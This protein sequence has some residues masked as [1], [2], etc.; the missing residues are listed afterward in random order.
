[1]ALDD[2]IT[3]IIE[4]LPED[5]GQV[6]LNV[7]MSQL[8]RLSATISRLDRDANEGRPGSYFRIAE[9]SYSS[10]MRVVIEPHSLP[11]QRYIGHMVV[12]SLN[13]I[14]EV[15]KHGDDLLVLEADLLE[16][17]RGLAKPVGK[18]LKNATLVFDGN[19]IDLT[20]GMTRRLDEAL[21]VDE[22]CD[23]SIDGMLEQ[24][25]IHHGA[26]TFHIFP[27]IGP[28][29]VSCRFPTKL[30]DEAV[31]AVGRRVEVSGTLHY[32]ANASFPHQIA[33]S[34]IEAFPP[35]S[36]LPDWDDLRGRAPDATGTLSS[37]AFVRELRD[38]WR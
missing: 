25:N 22:K 30:Y 5:E 38:A 21:A 10:P 14:A 12:E 15:L 6:R 32:R 29:K 28:K 18:T 24:I 1:M 37:E 7:F 36:E 23:G 3:L 19:Q 13:R 8:Q 17:F 26:N 35:D 11:G 31:S 34:H 27:E 16:E 4:G 9:L 33:V 20:E 2:R